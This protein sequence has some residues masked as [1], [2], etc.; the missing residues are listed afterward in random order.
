MPRGGA[1][2][3]AGRKP[4]SPNSG[5]NSTA[6]LRELVMVIAPVIN[7]ISPLDFMLSVISTPE[8]PMQ[9][10]LDA[11]KAAAPYVHTRV[12]PPVA[13]TKDKSEDS[14]KTDPH[15]VTKSEWEK[16]LGEWRPN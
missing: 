16:M 5:G 10:R 12:A 7:G 3:G 13:P 6:A 4:G 14:R 15:L 11:A 2:A 1:R 9:L 8:V